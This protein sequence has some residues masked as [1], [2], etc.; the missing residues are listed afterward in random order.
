MSLY[1]RD[2][3]TNLYKG[4]KLHSFKVGSSAHNH[5]NGSQ[6]C[7]TPAARVRLPLTFFF[8]HHYFLKKTTLKYK[9]F[10]N[11]DWVVLHHFFSPTS[12]HD[13]R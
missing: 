13:K 9:E 8:A 7:L 6:V 11:N 1:I 4:R 5:F 12:T 2:W 3:N 10:I